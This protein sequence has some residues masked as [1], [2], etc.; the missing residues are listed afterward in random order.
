[1]LL[2]IQCDD[3]DVLY[4]DREMVEQGHSIDV[5]T[6]VNL[7]IEKGI[8][9]FKSYSSDDVPSEDDPLA[10]YWYHGGS[11]PWEREGGWWEFPAIMDE[12]VWDQVTS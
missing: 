12:I 5:E 3:W 11:D 4:L 9:A 10:C 7:V 6:V 1:M 8:T 2:L